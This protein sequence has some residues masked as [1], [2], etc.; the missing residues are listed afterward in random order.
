[1][2]NILSIIIFLAI[3]AAAG[4]LAG[5]ILKGSDFGLVLNIVIGVIGAFVGGFLFSILGLS[6]TGI[7]GSVISATC[8]AIVL[9]FVIGYIKKAN[10]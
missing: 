6:S 10:N 4:W 9:L 5:R 2:D 8:G 1:M 7:I 3:G